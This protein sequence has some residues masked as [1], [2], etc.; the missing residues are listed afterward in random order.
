MVF[1]VK[2]FYSFKLNVLIYDGIMFCP[3]VPDLALLVLPTDIVPQVLEDCGRKGIKH[4]IIVS[5]GF[6]GSRIQ[7]FE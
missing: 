3:K 5:G 7:G 6:K 2:V 4:A 1:F